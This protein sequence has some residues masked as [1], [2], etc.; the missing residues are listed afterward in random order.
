MHVHIFIYNHKVIAYVGMKSQR[1]LHIL[2]VY[3][4][5]YMREHYKKGLEIWS[6]GE[7]EIRM[8]EWPL[9]I[10]NWGPKTYG[11]VHLD[12]KD[13]T[14]LL[15]LVTVVIHHNGACGNTVQRFYKETGGRGRYQRLQVSEPSISILT[16]SFLSCLTYAAYL[17]EA[18]VTQKY[19]PFC[20]IILEAFWSYMPEVPTSRPA[21]SE[22]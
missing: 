4:I 21:G 7:L 6:N 12:E 5:W 22:H 14:V 20:V 15:H 10:D 11:M 1:P 18:H 2:Y 3:M 13:C 19:Y 17:S 8:R 16:L 9:Y